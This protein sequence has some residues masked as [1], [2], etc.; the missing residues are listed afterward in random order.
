M[1]FAKYC[2]S[3]DYL[4]TSFPILIYT[5]VSYYILYVFND[6]FI[7]S[8]E[9]VLSFILSLLLVISYWLLIHLRV[10]DSIY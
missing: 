8:V 2:S 4:Q 1:S 5:L 9:F 6:S 3:L 10:T 7:G